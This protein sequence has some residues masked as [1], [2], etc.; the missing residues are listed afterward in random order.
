MKDKIQN[1]A[2][3]E[4]DPELVADLLMIAKQGAATTT[5]EDGEITC[6][7]Q[8]TGSLA[9]MEHLGASSP[10]TDPSVK[11][12]Q[13]ALYEN[14]VGFPTVYI[15]PAADGKSVEVTVCTPRRERR[16]QAG[17]VKIEADGGFEDACYAG[18]PSETE[19][20]KRFTIRRDPIGANYICAGLCR[21]A[22]SQGMDQ[23]K[24]QFHALGLWRC[25]ENLVLAID[26]EQFYQQT[27]FVNDFLNLRQWNHAIGFTC[28]VP[29]NGLFRDHK[30]I[31][32]ISSKN[33]F[34]Q[35]AQNG[36]IIF[37]CRF[38]IGRRDLF[39]H[40]VWNVRVECDLWVVNFCFE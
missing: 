4:L 24:H 1:D 12:G 32:C 14:K 34:I 18:L 9:K 19:K 30:T 10:E 23:F 37:V 25:G 29:I 38:C 2:G 36:F 27:F 21:M 15:V 7:N 40:L 8:K 35:H 3:S 22:A 26:L 17:E 16:F 39:H 28:V 11:T 33:S 13:Q 20:I 5:P 31:G 6:P